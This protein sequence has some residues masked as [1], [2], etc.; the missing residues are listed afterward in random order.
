MS[1]RFRILDLDQLRLE[2]E[3]AAFAGSP[4]L[5][6]SFGL[7]AEAFVVRSDA[8]AAGARVSLEEALALAQSAAARADAALELPEDVD[9]GRTAALDA[10]ALRVR[11][12]GQIAVF[13]GA[14]GRPADTYAEFS[15]VR[16]VLESS[17]S[18]L[19]YGLVSMGFDPWNSLA[20]VAHPPRSVTESCLDVARAGDAARECRR[21]AAGLRV[22]VGGGAAIAA[23]A[24]LQCAARLAPLLD[25]SFAFSPLRCGSSCGSPSTR[26]DSRRRAR[27]ASESC[28]SA[29]EAAPLLECALETH[30]PFVRGPERWYPVAHELSFRTW[31]ERGHLGLFPDLDDFRSHLAALELPA[32]LRGWIEIDACDALPPPFDSVPLTLWSAV[33]EDAEARATLEQQEQATGALTARHVFGA[34]AGALLRRTSGWIA[35]EMLAAYVEF[36][37]RFVFRARTPSDDVL[38]LFAARRGFEWVQYRELLDAWSSACGVS[39]ARDDQR[40]A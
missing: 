40:A 19:G 12:G 31:M 10:P 37:R 18:A 5:R 33:L 25:A 22:F 38:A 8:R 11:A 39:T 4:V 1:S 17:A 24:R 3:R 32:R 26:S 36:G 16:G 6:D 29:L 21:L 9:F 28:A 14:F 27:A 20:S 23:A 35:P 34:A 7:E 2:V 30:V 13:S 15:R